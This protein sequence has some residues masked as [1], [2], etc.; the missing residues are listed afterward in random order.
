MEDKCYE[1]LVERHKQITGELEKAATKDLNKEKVEIKEKHEKEKIEIKEKHDKEK[2]ELQKKYED[3]M[4]ESEQ[5]YQTSLTHLCTREAHYDKLYDEE[6][7]LSK[8]L[9]KRRRRDEEDMAERRRRI[10]RGTAVR[11]EEA[12]NALTLLR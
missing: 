11:E 12:G 1:E 2:L 10:S 9:T 3:E 4:K 8:E 7:K 5:E 6:E